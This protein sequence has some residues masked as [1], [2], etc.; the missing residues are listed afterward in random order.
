M[1]TQVL[2]RLIDWLRGSSRQ[3][4]DRQRAAAARRV[5]QAR[6]GVRRWKARASDALAREQ[7]AVEHASAL[8][9][10]LGEIKRR[11]AVARREVPSVDVLR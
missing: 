9:R 7:A 8:D 11:I 6:A 4:H 5:E 2:R 10:Q 3:E 1:S